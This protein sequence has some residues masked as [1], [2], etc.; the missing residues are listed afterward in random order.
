MVISR[1][2]I[3]AWWR[4]LSLDERG[5]EERAESE[6]RATAGLRVAS[7][8]PVRSTAGVLGRSQDAR[9]PG[10]QGGKDLPAT[11]PNSGWPQSTLIRILVGDGKGREAA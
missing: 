5:R 11:S 3:L 6:R 4:G 8:T 9:E 1:R 10:S 7:D 2:A